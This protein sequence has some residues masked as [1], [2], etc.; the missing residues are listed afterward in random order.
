M[1]YTLNL[2]DIIPEKARLYRRYSIEAGKLIFGVNGRVVCSGWHSRTLRGEEIRTHLIVVEFPDEKALDFFLNDPAH[3][4]IHEMRENS[5]TNY[6][7]KI[8]EPWDLDAWV[9][10]R[11]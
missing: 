8:F 3:H 2:F 9:A 10:F 4:A 1:L 11:T 5:T 6:I 7:W